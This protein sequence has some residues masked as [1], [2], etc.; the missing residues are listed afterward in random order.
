MIAED[1]VEIAI[2]DGCH[3]KGD[4]LRSFGMVCLQRF[5]DLV[6]EGLN[7]FHKIVEAL[8][9]DHPE[10]SQGIAFAVATVYYGYFNYILGYHERGQV[11]RREGLAILDRLDARYEK[12]VA[13]SLSFYS[14]FES[15]NT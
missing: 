11:L 3:C 8:Q 14:D 12:A 5:D 9:T 15:D 4:T 7:V 6:E 10:G 13:S 1:I 2:V